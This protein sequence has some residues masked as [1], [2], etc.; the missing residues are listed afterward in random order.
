M[1]K[2]I[3]TV[4]KIHFRFKSYNKKMRDIWE[5][6]NL[7]SYYIQEAHQLIKRDNLPALPLTT[8]GG[9]HKNLTKDNTYGAISHLIR[10]ANPRR[11]LTDAVATFEH[12]LGSVIQAVYL[13]YPAKMLS[14]DTGSNVEGYQKLLRII[15]ESDDKEELIQKL[16]EEKVRGIFYGN[17]ANFFIKD[18]AKLEFGS[19]FKEH[20]SSELGVFS[21]VLARRNVIVHNDG[22]VD[23]KYLREVKNSEFSLNQMV[24]ADSEY[25]RQTILLLLGLSAEVTGLVAQNIYR[26][27]PKGIL[28]RVLK[29]FMKTPT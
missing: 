24:S 1:E 28:A 12:Y 19:Y 2:Q 6:Y 10:R 8:L 15:I 17:P 11:A 23:R 29:G 26:Q 22:R 9:G 21:E 16:V 25:L 18:P 13:D 5:S 4:V 27:K 14:A 3:P 7:V 20:Y